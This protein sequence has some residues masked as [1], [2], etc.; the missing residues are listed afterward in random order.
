[1]SPDDFPRE[2]LRALL[3]PDPDRPFCDEARFDRRLAHSR[4]RLRDHAHLLIPPAPR[5]FLRRALRHLFRVAR[6]DERD[7]VVLRMR[8]EGERFAD[9]A[10]ALGISV[11][12]AHS[13]WRRLRTKLRRAW[14]ADPYSDLAAVYRSETSRG[15][16]TSGTLAAFAR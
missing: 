5:P 2:F 6:L 3:D 8:A 16:P 1:M 13:A 14:D 7:L 4:R 15:R 9:V 12:A 11:Q 10:A